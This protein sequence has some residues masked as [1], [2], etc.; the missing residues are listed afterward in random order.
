MTQIRWKAAVSV[1]ED[2]VPDPEFEYRLITDD[3]GR[4]ILEI[5]KAGS[6][7]W[8]EVL[9]LDHQTPLILFL[10]DLSGSKIKDQFYLDGDKILVSDA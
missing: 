4:L 1:V 10:C 3:G 2:S 7:D 5:K 9:W 6:E 8:T